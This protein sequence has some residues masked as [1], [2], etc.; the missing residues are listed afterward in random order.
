MIYNESCY[1]GGLVTD[2][3][4]FSQVMDQGAGSSLNLAT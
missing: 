1:L 4:T 3:L 2:L